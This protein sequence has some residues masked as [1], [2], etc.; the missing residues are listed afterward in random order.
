MQG[1]L[2]QLPPAFYPMP[3]H[4]NRAIYPINSFE[5]EAFMNQPQPR[6]FS[7]YKHD[8]NIV[9]GGELDSSSSSPRSVPSAG[10]TTY[11]QP[12]PLSDATSCRSQSIYQGYGHLPNVYEHY[13]SSKLVFNPPEDHY[14][15]P[16]QISPTTSDYGIAAPQA[17]LDAQLPAGQVFPQ[18]SITDTA[19]SDP[20]KAYLLEQFNNPEFADCSLIL[21]IGGQA[22]TFMLHSVVI[23]QIPTLKALLQSSKVLDSEGRKT[24]VLE[25]TDPHLTL[26]VVTSALQTCYGE[27]PPQ[28]SQ[29]INELESALAYLATGRLFQLP[30]Y[31]DIGTTGVLKFLTLE[32]LVKVMT[33]ALSDAANVET[34]AAAIQETGLSY[35]SRRLFEG[36]LDF[37][38]TNFPNPFVLDLCA[39]NS[40]ALG[41][42]PPVP[43]A[44]PQQQ[45]QRPKPELM[46]IR[47]G[48][49]PSASHSIPSV[50]STALSSILLSVPFSVLQQIIQALG[51]SATQDIAGPIIKERER[52][53]LKAL[54]TGIKLT[55]Q[56]GYSPAT[57][58]LERHSWGEQVVAT[59]SG[60]T[61]TR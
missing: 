6:L 2:F 56:E 21:E 47:F 5:I 40:T 59:H 48:E 34:D 25:K 32:N 3:A 45:Q 57:D 58:D 43:L 22:T 9:F 49:F 33:Y 10:S 12:T 27:A 54:E 4:S 11:T 24:L 44:E 1:N 46:S 7:P 20:L 15:Q 61:T 14:S 26:P 60:N 55:T 42:H 35:P 19:A 52:R 28:D 13:A 39:P 29:I 30:L 17:H 36:L 23:A 8:P 37:M 16:P 18:L 53:R 51:Q 41:G 31:E 50:E 38:V